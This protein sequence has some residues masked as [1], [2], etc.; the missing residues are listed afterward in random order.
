MKL[1]VGS[2]TV[3]FPDWI[4]IDLQPHAGA[5]VH[6]ARTRF[7]YTDGS[8]DFKFCEHFIE[9]LNEPEGTFF[10]TEC[11][12]MLKPGG[13]IRTATFDIDDIMVQCLVEEKW[14]EYKMFLYGGIFAHLTRTQFFNLAVY[15]AGY[16]KWMY[17]PEE[18]ERIMRLAGFTQFSRP[19]MKESAFPELQNRECRCNSNCIVEAIR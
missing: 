8:V 15:E 4:N 11:F 14:N 16:H 13:V 10:F 7:P 5:I 6:D 1:N 19:Q 9:H 18:M 17:N 2:N 12:R 3:V